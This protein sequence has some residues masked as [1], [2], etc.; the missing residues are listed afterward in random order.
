M[1]RCACL[2]SALYNAR[3]AVSLSATLSL[4]TGT[5]LFVKVRWF[6]ETGGG[7]TVCE[8]FIV[9]AAAAAAGAGPPE[10][11]RELPPAVLRE[12]EPDHNTVK[13]ITR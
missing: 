7:F 3:E 5:F 13:S 8:E 6:P 4:I 11:H 2:T 1:V 10:L 9:A 12:S